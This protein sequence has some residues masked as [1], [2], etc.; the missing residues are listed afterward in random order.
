MTATVR[1]TH[2]ATGTEAITVSVLRTDGVL[3]GEHTLY[4]G[5]THNVTIIDGQRIAIIEPA[6]LFAQQ[7]H[8]FRKSRP[9]LPA[10]STEQ[11]A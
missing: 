8:A 9:A 5:D 7:F 4:P 10:D 6:P 3:V 1:I 2:I 11:T